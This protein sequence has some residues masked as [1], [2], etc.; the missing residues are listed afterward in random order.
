MFRLAQIN[1]V[2]AAAATAVGINMTFLFP[3]S[4][5]RKGWN[6][7][8]R[9]LVKFDLSTGMFI[10]YILA[11]GCVVIASATQFHGQM[12][13]NFV[14]NEKSG[15]VVVPPEF[16]GNYDKLI[17]GREQDKNIAEQNIPLSLA[18]QRLAA[19]LVE[20]QSHHLSSSLEN[21]TG[22]TVGGLIFGLGVLAMTFSTI[23]LLMLI[24]GFVFAEMFNCR[25]GGW[26]H[27]LGML[28]A[29]IGGMF[30]PFLWGDAKFYLAVPTSGNWIDIAPLCLC[31]ICLHDEF[32][33]FTG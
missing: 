23:S 32:Q 4:L 7:Q 21:L 3:Y 9:G 1:K 15:E 28:V 30:G 13:E 12:G 27:R 6:K 20:R 2:A 11:T 31:H 24:S 33:K 10:P 16:K 29:G 26:A 19:T 14:I 5:L 22:K 18:E 25:P 8:Y 17:S